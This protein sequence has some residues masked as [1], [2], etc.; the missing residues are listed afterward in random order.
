MPDRVTKRPLGFKLIQLHQYHLNQLRLC[1]G[2][3]WAKRVDL[4]FAFDDVDKGGAGGE[5]GGGVGGLVQF[6]EGFQG[7]AFALGGG[8]DQGGQGLGG[9]LQVV[10]G[11]L[12]SKGLKGG[13]L[14]LGV[15]DEF[16]DVAVFVIQCAGWVLLSAQSEAGLQGVAEGL[17]AVAVHG[18]QKGAELRVG[19]GV[20]RGGQGELNQF[21][22]GGGDLLLQGCHGVGLGLM[23]THVRPRIKKAPLGALGCR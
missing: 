15:F 11:G 17:P 20:V 10:G 5:G 23:Y 14:S 12:L 6:S 2:E 4:T 18:V 1:V 7:F 21:K 9:V 16:E 22:V 3:R 8:V 19:I 13:R